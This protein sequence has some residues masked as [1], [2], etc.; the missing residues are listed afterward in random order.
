MRKKRELGT[1]VLTFVDGEQ[2]EV[3]IHAVPSFVLMQER[4]RFRKMQHNA[5]GGVKSL[6]FSDEEF[7][8]KI[9]KFSVGSQLSED[10]LK[11]VETDIRKIYEKYFSGNISPKKKAKSSDMCQNSQDKE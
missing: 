8:V 2:K 10:D 4:R 1:E 7:I 3:I 5:N 9:L 6:D 11:E